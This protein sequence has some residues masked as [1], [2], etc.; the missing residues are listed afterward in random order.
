MKSSNK[1]DNKVDGNKNLKSITNRY[2]VKDAI[3]DDEKKETQDFWSLYQL[4]CALKKKRMV[5]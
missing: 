4:M 3:M 2:K 5:I 1:I